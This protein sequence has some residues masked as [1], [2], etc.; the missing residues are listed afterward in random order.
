MAT[1]RSRTAAQ[2][3]ALTVGAVYLVVGLVGFAVT[4]VDRFASQTQEELIVLGINPLHNIV[5]IV[6]G[7]VW[8][9]A[10]ITHNGAK[11]VNLLLG[12]VLL[13]IA[14]FGFGG[15][16][17]D[18]LISANTADDVLH[19]ATGAAGIYFGTAGALSGRPSM[20]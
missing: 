8:L 10:A 14:V 19:L 11:R 6:L 4:G 18:T 15:V 12:A 16:L 5:H 1:A 17:V 3:F 13:A 9:G 20:S 7:V 2:V